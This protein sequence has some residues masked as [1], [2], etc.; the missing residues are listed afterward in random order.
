MDAERSPRPSRRDRPDHNVHAGAGVVDYYAA[1]AD[2]V[3]LE[4]MRSTTLVRR[5]PVGV[6]GLIVPWNAPLLLALMKIAPALLAGCTVVLKPAA[7]TSLSA[8]FLTDATRAAGLPPGVVNIVTGGRETGSALVA[9][10]G[11]DKIGFTGSTAAGRIV[12]A[13]C[14][15]TLKPATF[16]L[17]GKSA[18]ILLDDAELDTYL[19]RITEV[20]LLGSGQ[21]CLL[22][23]RLLVA[24]SRHDELCDR[25]RETL[26]AQVVGNPLDPATTFG[27]ISL[28]RQRAHVEDYIRIGR[29]EG[30]AVLVGGGRPA[31]LDHG[32]FVE[33]TVFVGVDNGMR[34][35]REEIFGPVLT[36]TPFDDEDHAV[37]LANDSEYGLGGSVFSADREHE[38]AVARRVQTGT[39]GVNGYQL[40]LAAP[41]GGVRNSGIGRE[42]G[43]EGLAPYQRLQSIYHAG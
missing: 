13:Q 26:A 36:V 33:P 30:A 35:A 37:A 4:E 28:Q 7:E 31:H 39:I 40:D 38:V 32:F 14:G 5:E 25:L 10:P 12:A 34:I 11:V 3:R 18:A 21:G 19:D 22:S 24:R 23:T 16:E 42:L 2:E 15:Q 1:V 17:G 8:A 29:D 43:P 20:S 6:A 41:F 27:P 9:H